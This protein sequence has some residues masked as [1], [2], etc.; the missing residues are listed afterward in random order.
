MTVSFNHYDLVCL[1]K[2]N[3]F[4]T[5]EVTDKKT[6]IWNWL[7]LQFQKAL[8]RIIYITYWPSIFGLVWKLRFPL[9]FQLKLLAG[10]PAFVMTDPMS[11]D[12]VPWFQTFELLPTSSTSVYLAGETNEPIRALKAGM[13]IWSLSQENEKMITSVVKIH[14]CAGYCTSTHR[15][16]NS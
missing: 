8:T 14:G 5:V 15:N 2:P 1:P 11:P 16:K 9:E 7:R 12:K 10:Q 4:L 13:K 6:A 3:K